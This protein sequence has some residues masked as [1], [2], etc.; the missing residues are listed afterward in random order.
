MGTP[1]LF[2]QVSQ[3]RALI[4]YIAHSKPIMRTCDSISNSCLDF[5]SGF[6]GNFKVLQDTFELTLG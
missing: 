5:A 2:E 3:A 6:I 4:T 1:S